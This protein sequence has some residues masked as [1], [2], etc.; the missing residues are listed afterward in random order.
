MLLPG[1][2]PC[3]GLRPAPSPSALH[4][5]ARVPETPIR[6]RSGI[7]WTGAVLLTEG[8]FIIMLGLSCSKEGG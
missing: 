8:V 4:I 2:A 1:H 7:D 5:T 6:S 3:S